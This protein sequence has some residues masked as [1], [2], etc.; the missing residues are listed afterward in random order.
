MRF[1]KFLPAQ[2]Q[3]DELKELDL[4]SHLRNVTFNRGLASLTTALQCH[5]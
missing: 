5:L 4:T 3:R 1:F 2:S